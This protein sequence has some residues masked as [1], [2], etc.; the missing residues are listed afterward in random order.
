MNKKSINSRNIL[1]YVFLLFNFHF[2]Q[3]II[4]FEISVLLQAVMVDEF[5]LVFMFSF[6]RKINKLKK[7][8]KFVFLL[9]NFCSFIDLKSVYYFKLY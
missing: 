5:V 6:E 2:Y 7:N 8:Y 9:F 4:D 3:S 1:S